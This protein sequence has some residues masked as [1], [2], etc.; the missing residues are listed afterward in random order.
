MNLTKNEVE[1]MDTLWAVGKPMSRAELI[2]MPE[3]RTW[4]ES[5]IHVLLNSL[6][7]KGA[8]C[9]AG[10]VKNGKAIGRTYAAAVTCEEYYAQS[11]AT[12]TKTKPE[13]D[14]LL[15]SLLDSFKPNKETLEKMQA[16][17]DKALS[18]K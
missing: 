1:I 11:A 12:N 18:K 16:V 3:T 9:E 7:R 4:K 5:S 8:V 13:L 14:I 6:L 2:A 10:F 17:L 15:K